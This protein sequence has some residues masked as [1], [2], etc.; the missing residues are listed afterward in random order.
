M[1]EVIKVGL[2]TDHTIVTDILGDPDAAVDT[3]GTLLPDLIRRA[4]PVKADVVAEDFREDPTSD[5]VGR[6]VLNYGH[7]FGHA[8]EKVERYRWRHGAAV[9]VGMVYVAELANLA[10]RLSDERVAEHRAVLE[11]VGLPTRYSG[12][13]WPALLEAMAIDK[14]T[15]GSTLRF[16]IMTDSGQP[17]ILRGPD[18]ALLQAAF[19]AVGA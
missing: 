2:T 3:A 4:V 15:R 18:P 14:K 19:A 8:I 13:N 12:G 7:T 6:E 1:A 10:G 5:D 16:V 9:S 11:A 17:A